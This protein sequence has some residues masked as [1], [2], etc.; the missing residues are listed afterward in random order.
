M[1]LDVATEFGRKVRG[2]KEAP[3][4]QV[5]TALEYCSSRG[6]GFSGPATGL[7]SS[8]DWFLN[9]TEDD[10][11]E[12]SPEASFMPGRLR[13]LLPVSI[14]HMSTSKCI[15]RCSGWARFMQIEE[16]SRRSVVHSTERRLTLDRLSVIWRIDG[17]W[18]SQAR[19]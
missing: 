9:S 11:G 10:D 4:F 15:S 6:L 12:V 13:P 2:L 17:I 8:L 18:D 1:S 16:W 5:S 14:C 3:V 19:T 7:M